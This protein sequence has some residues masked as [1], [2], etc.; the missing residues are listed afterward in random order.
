MTATL[1]STVHVGAEASVTAPLR[2]LVVDDDHAPAEL[3]AIALPTEPELECVGT[4]RSAA[5]AVVMAARLRPDVVVVGTGASRR[6]GLTATRRL[7]E[8][9]PEL[10][11]VVVAG[12]TPERVTAEPG[13]ELTRR[14]R[15]VL[16]C[17]SRG[18]PPKAIAR[19][20]GISLHTCRGYVKSLLS[21]L[22]VRSQL[23]AVVT[24]QRLGLVE[25]SGV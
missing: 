7:R 6:E 21:K 8:V 1:E 13:V 19:L 10:L 24:A 15:D 4:A 11:I 9:V 16:R 12:P 22:G 23:E 20:L 2:V 18:M 14:E 17:L 5:E 3:L 25:P